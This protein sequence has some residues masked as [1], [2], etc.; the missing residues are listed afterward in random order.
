[1]DWAQAGMAMSPAAHTT[2]ETA[3]RARAGVDGVTDSLPLVA[4]IVGGAPARWVGGHGTRQDRPIPGDPSVALPEH[5]SHGY[6][7]PEADVAWP[8]GR[9][10]GGRIRARVKPSRSNWRSSF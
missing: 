3:G 6:G 8:D 9:G 5:P 4:V 1:M 2:H 10:I 7:D